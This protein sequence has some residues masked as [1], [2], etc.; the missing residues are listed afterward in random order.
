MSK[1][2][3]AAFAAYPPDVEA[4]A[5]R[6]RTFVLDTLPDAVEVLDSTRKILGYCYGPGYAGTVCTLILSKKGVKIGIVRG[7][8][9]PDPHGLMAGDGIYHRHVELRTPKDL[10]HRG[11]KPLL[12]TALVAWKERSE[13][14][15]A[16][17]K[18][19]TT[20]GKR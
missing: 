11:L 3:V 17:A 6:A 1:P 20:K 18:K 9:L 10:E 2:I 4:L 19:R 13:K 14:A 5:L 12:L 15:P 8:D 16:R 7:A